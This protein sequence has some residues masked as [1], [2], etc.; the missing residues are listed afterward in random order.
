MSRR[1]I[2]AA[3]LLLAAVSWTNQAGAVS[4][5][6][7]WNIPAPDGYAVGGFVNHFEGANKSNT[8]VITVNLTAPVSNGTAGA[9]ALNI[10]FGSFRLA[11][12]SSFSWTWTSSNLVTNVTGTFDLTNQNTIALP[13]TATDPYP[14]NP[15]SSYF[16]TINST[17]AANA[18]AGGGYTYSIG[19][20]DCPTCA[21]PPP[22]VPVPPAA[23]LFV[24]GLAGLGL[25]GRKRRKDAGLSQ[26]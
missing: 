24:S 17:T 14:G 10:A 13:F 23:I 18:A 2:L 8:D 12:F 25:L 21:P 26:A 4:Y 15:Y 16:L 22:T 9:V 6:K 5:T 11:G 1:A 7:T 19:V 20:T 3:G